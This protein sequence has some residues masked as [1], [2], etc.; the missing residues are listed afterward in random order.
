MVALAGEIGDGLLFSSGYLSH[1]AESLRDPGDETRRSGIF[2]G[3]RIRICIDPDRVRA[4]AV[5]RKTMSHYAL[6]PSYRNYWIDAGYA[7]EMHAVAVAMA[8]NRPND[9]GNCFSD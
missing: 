5:L 9:V 2:I 8:E 4:K 6:M 3:N 7:D 1:M